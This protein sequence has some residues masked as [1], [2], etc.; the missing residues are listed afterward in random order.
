VQR[1]GEGWLQYSWWRAIGTSVM[2]LIA[3]LGIIAVA[4]SILDLYQ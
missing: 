2:I 1:R 3:M 4:F